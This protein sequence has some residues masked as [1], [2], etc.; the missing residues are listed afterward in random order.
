MQ[1]RECNLD[2]DLP[3]LRACAIELQ[4]FERAL[5]PRLPEGDKMAD[6]YLEEVFDRARKFA[7]KFFVAEIDGQVVG[8]VS[9]LGACQLEEPSETPAPFAYVDDLLV[10]PKHR[11]QGIGKALLAEA[12]GYAKRCGRASI[13]LCVKGG[14]HQARAFYAKAGYGEYE[15]ELEKRL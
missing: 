1:I 8:L 3:A 4:D 15:L 12:E 9:V 7:G 11:G 10:L 5:D 2:R 6:A 13:R 14:N